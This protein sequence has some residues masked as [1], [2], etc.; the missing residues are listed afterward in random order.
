MGVAS[1]P[2]LYETK[3]EAIS[4]SSRLRSARRKCSFSASSNAIV[5]R[6]EEAL[7]RIAAQMPAA[8][9][10]K[11]ADFVIQTDGT[12]LE[13]DRQVDELIITLDRLKP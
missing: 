9:K 10:A 12:M 11:R 3:R 4:T 1:I 2:L 6:R 13:T 8:E 7:R 5:C